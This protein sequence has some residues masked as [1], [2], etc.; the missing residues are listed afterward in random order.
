MPKDASS[1]DLDALMRRV[2]EYRRGVIPIR[3]Q[4]GDSVVRQ[5]VL[6]TRSRLLFRPL[7][8]TFQIQVN[9]SVDGVDHIGTI[10][11]QLSI[12]AALGSIAWGSVLGAVLGTLV[13]SLAQP[14][15]SFSGSHLLSILQ[16]LAVSVMASIAVMVA[17]ARKS[18]AQPLVSIEDFWGGL[19]I[20]F[21]V[22]YFGFQT[23]FRLFP[24][25]G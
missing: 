20:G 5:F 13:K 25:S 12:Q 24:T 14:G 22:G 7:S 6:R 18:S 9:Y 17:F 23:F 11:Y 10:P 21:T 1:D 19:V 3:L 2:I 15:A 16:A 4:P 8:H